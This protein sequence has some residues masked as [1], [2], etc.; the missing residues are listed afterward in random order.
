MKNAFNLFMNLIR[1][2][3]LMLVFMSALSANV[4]IENGFKQV[5][6]EKENALIPVE[7]NLPIENNEAYT[8]VQFN[9]EIKDSLGEIYLGT[10]LYETVEVYLKETSTSWTKISQLAYPLVDFF[11]LNLEQGKHTILLGYQPYLE[12]RFSTVKIPLQLLSHSSFELQYGYARFFGICFLGAMF[13]FALYHL[14]L[15]VVTKD[16]SYLYYFLFITCIGFFCVSMNP[17]LAKQLYGEMNPTSGV[18]FFLGAVSL[19]FHLALFWAI[20]NLK[21]EFSRLNKWIK[22]LYISIGAG[23]IVGLFGF[24][25]IALFLLIPLSATSMVIMT[26]LNL[27]LLFEKSISGLFFFIGTLLFTISTFI[28]LGMLVE[29]LPSTVLGMTIGLQME[30]F[31]VLGAIFWASSLSA[32]I[33]Q[34]NKDAN[35]EE[36]ENQRL[37]RIQEQELLILVEEQNKSL[38][39]NVAERTLSL[40]EKNRELED[41]ILQLQQTQNQLIEKEKMASLG[42]LTAGVAHEINN[43]INFISN[44]ISNLKLNYQDLVDALKGY[45]HLNPKEAKAEDLKNIQE[46]NAYLEIAEIIEE[47]KILFKSINNGVERT[48]KIVHGLSTFSNENGESYLPTDLHQCLDSTLEILKNKLK[49]TIEIRKDY[50]EIPKVECQESRINQVFLNIIN[51]AAQAMEASGILTIKTGKEADKVIISIQ[52]NGAGMDSE[53]QRKIFDPFFTTKEIGVGTGLG[54][55]ISYKIIEQHQG[56]LSFESTP[57]QGT[58]FYIKLPL[59]QQ[60]STS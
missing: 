53:T 24:F 39:E 38:E 54:L 35:L 10:N 30:L 52:D 16:L 20:F 26:W 6:L 21:N 29:W 41:S 34:M 27:K 18:P 22:W 45:L 42:Q 46:K 9:L 60:Q 13:L 51:N 8:W 17:Y 49:N 40:K 3:F 15:Y 2:M 47:N 31:Y 11:P 19:T 7:G 59:S 37:K 57:G 25:K 44:G 1:I 50:R 55:S 23:A 48:R 28:L 12:D 14:L 4:I 32:R 36:I 43:P 58:T 33:S 56:E 5:F